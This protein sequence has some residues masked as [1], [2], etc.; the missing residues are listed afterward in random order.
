M[1]RICV[2]LV[3]LSWWL[4]NSLLTMIANICTT[5]IFIT[6]LAVI[7]FGFR[8]STTIKEK[9]KKLIIC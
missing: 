8:L 4:G 1:R 5:K 3:G 2:R 7:T 9:E 6:L